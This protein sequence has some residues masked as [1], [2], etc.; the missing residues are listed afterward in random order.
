MSSSFAFDTLSEG[1]AHLRELYTELHRHPELS[2]E[3]HATAGRIAEELERIGCTVHRGGDVWQVAVP[4]W[5]PD[6]TA[7]EDLAEEI[8]NHS[9][10]TPIDD[11]RSALQVVAANVGIAYAPLPL[12]KNLARKQVKALPLRGATG[13]LS[14]IALVWRKADDSDA[15]QDFVGVTK[16]RTARSSRG[17]S[18]PRSGAK[19]ARR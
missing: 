15:V 13:S 16:G 17:Q 19:K 9:G 1:L 14:Q 4:S 3:E 6:L 2:S 11:L 12:L 8:V 18:H 5:R 7:E 10:P